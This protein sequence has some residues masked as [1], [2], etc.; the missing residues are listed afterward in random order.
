MRASAT[1]AATH[2][3]RSPR[4]N[5]TTLEAAWVAHAAVVPAGPMT[6]ERQSPSRIDVCG[7]CSVSGAGDARKFSRCC[8]GP[9]SWAWPGRAPQAMLRGVRAADTMRLPWRRRDKHALLRPAATGL[10][11][12][13]DAKLRKLRQAVRWQKL[14]IATLHPASAPAQVRSQALPFSPN[15]FEDMDSSCDAAREPCARRQAYQINSRVVAGGLT[16]TTQLDQAPHLNHRALR[17]RRC[18]A[19]S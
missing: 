17:M 18:L 16:L 4:D 19:G 2:V 10:K 13:S 3:P 5:A 9:P 8:D 7:G 11:H 1:T 15:G 6:A 14:V 12:L